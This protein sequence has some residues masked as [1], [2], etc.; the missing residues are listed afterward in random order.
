MNGIDLT[1]RVAVVTGG[2][3]GIGR[4]TA[5]RLRD[6]G[7]TVEVWDI[8]PTP[9]GLSPPI[10]TSATRQRSRRQPMPPSGATALFTF[11]SAP[12]ES[13]LDDRS[14]ALPAGRLGAGAACQPHRRLPRLP[15][16]DPR[17]AGC[18]LGPDR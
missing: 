12:P 8:L 15:G 3:S 6:C 10:P 5:E 14:R 1:S 4:R 17:D 11:S 7:A 18:R 2:A 9:R 13:N 16:P